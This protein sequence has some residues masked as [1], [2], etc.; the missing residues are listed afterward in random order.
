MRFELGLPPLDFL[1]SLI[2]HAKLARHVLLAQA[3]SQ[4]RNPDALAGFG[5]PIGRYILRHRGGLQVPH[6]VARQPAEHHANQGNAHQLEHDVKRNARGDGARLEQPHNSQAHDLQRGQRVF[7][8]FHA[9]RLRRAINPGKAVAYGVHTGHV[10]TA[11]SL[12][13]LLHLRTS[14]RRKCPPAFR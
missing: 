10:F 7:P 3:Y 6:P 1:E 9:P 5:V 12:G 2:R 11:T 8:Q 13:P 4:A 14:R